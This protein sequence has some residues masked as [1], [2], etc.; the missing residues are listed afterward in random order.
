MLE[1]EPEVQRSREVHV[2]R[3]QLRTQAQG[4]KEGKLSFPLARGAE[5]SL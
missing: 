3:E 4:S 2:C 5:V 1:E